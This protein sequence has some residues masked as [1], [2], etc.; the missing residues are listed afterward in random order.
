MS[1]RL[2]LTLLAALLFS[3]QARAQEEQG[4]GH[5][6]HDH[7]HAQE[8]EADTAPEPTTREGK[9]QVAYDELMAASAAELNE[10]ASSEDQARIE[11]EFGAFRVVLEDF[12]QKW[13]G[14]DA[15]LEALRD[16]GM[17]DIYFLEK[18]DRG[19]ERLGEVYE[20]SKK[21]TKE[22]LAESADVNPTAIGIMYAKLLMEHERFD[23]A[24]QVLNSLEGLEDL[25]DRERQQLEFMVGRIS[26]LEKLRIGAPLPQ[27]S[28]KDL[29][30]KELTPAQYEGKVTL[31]DFW[32]TWCKPCVAEMPNVV[33][34]YNKYHDK[35]FDVVG[36]S[37]DQEGGEEKIRVF[38]EKFEMP[39]RHVFDG[40]GWGSEVAELFA[41][42]SIPYTILV[43]RNGIIR[44]KG[45]RG[46]ELEAAVSELLTENANK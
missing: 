43:D 8:H 16:T 36:I 42:N 26:K 5:E 44:H 6:G 4:Q 45:L 22:Q 20:L 17:L 46:A 38:A 29:D 15:A 39:W 35:G 13:E 3:L 1:S 28:G 9:A 21:R 18:I 24:S 25:E 37:L 10:A 2:L 32:A 23:K 33:E 19:L 31:Y 30:D 34:V 11:K 14:T 7:A 27:F 12:A 41:V 40:G